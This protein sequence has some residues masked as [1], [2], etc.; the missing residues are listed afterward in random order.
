MD[1][2]AVRIK[3]KIE[4]MSVHLKMSRSSSYGDDGGEG[5]SGVVKEEKAEK[6]VRRIRHFNLPLCQGM[7]PFIALAT[8]PSEL[9]SSENNTTE[10]TCHASAGGCS[11]HCPTNGIICNVCVVSGYTV[12]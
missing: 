9:Q 7:Y 5:E 11:N 1:T 8:H 3:K 12:A 4:E 10:I 2:V 6:K